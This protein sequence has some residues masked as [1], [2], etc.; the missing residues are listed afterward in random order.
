MPRGVVGHD[1]PMHCVHLGAMWIASTMRLE[2]IR[3]A[4]EGPYRRTPADLRDLTSR[5]E[6]DEWW[7]AVE[8][9]TPSK[10]RLPGI[11][12]IVTP[13]PQARMIPASSASRSIRPPDAGRESPVP[14]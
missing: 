13:G 14:A 10:R 9:D 7:V 1:P 8:G 11:P 12:R 4:L 3:N 6:I 5:A 2:P